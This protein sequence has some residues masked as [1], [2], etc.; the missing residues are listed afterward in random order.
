MIPSKRNLVIERGRK[1]RKAFLFNKKDKE[2]G[3]KTPFDFTGVT[4]ES[5]LRIAKSR[6]STLIDTFTVSFYA[7]D[8]ASGTVVIE[9]TDIQ[10]DAIP[11]NITLCYYDLVAV[12]DS[13]QY[14]SGEVIIE[15]TVTQTI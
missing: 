7:D 6:S 2:T 14:V 13:I 10:T 4:F 5:E 9:L 3:V 12:P 8:P 11:D 1:F 15:K